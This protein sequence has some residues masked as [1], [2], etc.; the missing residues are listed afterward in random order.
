MSDPKVNTCANCVDDLSAYEVQCQ[1]F[2]TNQCYGD[3][4]AYKYDTCE[5]YTMTELIYYGLNCE[6]P[7]AIKLELGTLGGLTPSEYCASSTSGAITNHYYH[8]VDCQ[9]GGTTMS[10]KTTIVDESSTTK[11][12]KSGTFMHSV[13]MSISFTFVATLKLF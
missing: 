2:I 8:T 12:D 6:D 5:N 7:T 10:P 3:A 1:A 9:V 13:V 4:G 11:V